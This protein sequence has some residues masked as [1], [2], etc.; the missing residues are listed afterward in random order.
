MERL[1]KAI[2]V[3][4]AA[5]ALA[6]MIHFVSRGFPPLFRVTVGAG[7]IAGVLAVLVGDAALTGLLF[8]SCV[9][10]VL[11]LVLTGD[12][13]YHFMPWLAALFG[14]LMAKSL[15]TGWSFPAGWK[16][17]LIL[18]TLSVALVWPIVVA[19][20]LDFNPAL[21]FY[22]GRLWTSRSGGA[23][24]A[25]V[26][27]T[28]SL[29]CSTLF[30]LLWLDWLFT[31]YSSA[32]LKRF[33]SRIVWPLFAGAAI[34]A[35]AAVYQSFG[36][37]TFLNP[38]VYGGLG[39]AAGT[40]LDGNAFGVVAAMW[41][42][43]IAAL[44]LS[45]ISRRTPIFLG[46]SIV[47]TVVLAAFGR[48]VW[49]TGSRTG[50]LTAVV[51]TTVFILSSWRSFS[52]TRTRA[53][54]AGGILAAVLTAVAVAGFRSDSI[55]SR[56]IQLLLPDLSSQSLGL[57]WNELWERNRYGTSAVRMIIDH[58][59]VGVGLGGFHTQVSDAA[60]LEGGASL[61][62]DNA[63]NWFRHQLAETG[64]LGSAGWLVFI[65]LFLWQLV[66]GVRADESLMA[67]A[68]R[69]SIVGVGMASL[70][71]M[72]TQ[73]IAVFVALL[74]FVVWSFK[75]NAPQPA[76]AM[77]LSTIGRGQWLLIGGVLGCFL[78]G[79]AYAGWNDLRPPFRAMRAEWPYQ[80]GFH[81]QEPGSDLRWTDGKAVDVFEIGDAREYRWVKLTLGAVAP[82]ADRRPVE[83][84]VW[85][86]HQLILRLT[87]RSDTVKN[88]YVR[89]PAGR[90]MM[91]L[92]IE[93]SRTWRPADD[94]GSDRRERGVM[95]GVW[96]F[97]YD[98]P[99][100]EF[101]IP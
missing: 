52:P 35:A 49:A 31:R 33:E 42:P 21:F 9:S 43:P 36:H 37:V 87:R 93:T 101:Q 65:A 7:V 8:L 77:P 68:A 26:A 28:V 88:W 89:V 94:G 84:K 50:L 53:L 38:T 24:P 46:L 92:Q 79:T 4:S 23:P 5:A 59:L 15:G 10:P 1:T 62:S 56:R 97:V 51:G 85:R 99:K 20:E 14:F 98:P 39:R 96:R 72:P 73:D 18:W 67:G 55:M 57:A 76:A 6:L 19:R 71:G 75:L 60:Y 90:K 30:G 41:L 12:F 13:T 11:F 63:Q 25:T 44:A 80:Y 83:I 58:P 64:L 66:R 82:D 47:W 100:G 17:P 81:E 32:S 74:V 22:Q 70:L 45:S 16:A 34:S 86:D 78:A 69:G 91:M 54:I 61:P 2:V 95:V 29:V 48:A 27:W 40:L 3:L